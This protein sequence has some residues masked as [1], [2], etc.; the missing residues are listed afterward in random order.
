MLLSSHI[1]NANRTATQNDLVGGFYPIGVG[2]EP[3]LHLFSDVKSFSISAVGIIDRSLAISFGSSDAYA[4]INTLQNGADNSPVSISNV[5]GSSMRSI[6]P[7]GQLTL[8]GQPLPV[9]PSTLVDYAFHSLGNGAGNLRIDFGRTL[10]KNG[11]FYP[12]ISLNFSNG[13][14]SEPIG[15]PVGV[16]DFAGYGSIPIYGGVVVNGI[17]IASAAGSIAINEKYSE[18]RTASFSASVGSVVTFSAPRALQSLSNYTKAYF[19]AVAAL[20]T[21]TDHSLS[22][23]VPENAKSGPVRFEANSPLFDTFLSYDS[24]VIS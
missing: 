1:V 11:L 5:N 13:L 20:V 9:T 3:F 18:L 23:T 6:I 17:V 12:R 19:G 10:I 7:I 8:A 14:T 22:V 16:V 2:L 24:V 15:R 4:G 21:A